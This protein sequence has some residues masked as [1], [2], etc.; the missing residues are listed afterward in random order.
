MVA[1]D[2]QG[3]PVAGGNPD[4]KFGM[5]HLDSG[6]Y[7]R[8]AAMDSVKPER[9]HVVGEAAGTADTGNDYEFLAWKR[10]F[11]EH[12]LQGGQNGVVSA[13]RPPASFLIGQ[14]VFLG[15]KWH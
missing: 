8:R 5:R 1:A 10:Q 12:R 2:G 3:I 6:G 4:F 11:R 15:Q 14:Q 13:A 7:R 9:V